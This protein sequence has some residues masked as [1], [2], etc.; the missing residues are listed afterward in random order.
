MLRLFPSMA[1]VRLEHTWS[2]VLGV[3][4]DWSASVNYNRATGLVTAGGYV[5]HGVA[6]TN[7]AAR[8]VRDLILGADTEI[9]ALP[10]VG[11]RSRSWEPEPTRWIGATSLYAVYGMADRLERRGTKPSKI[12]KLADYVSGRH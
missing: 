7:L 6:G 1:G 2:G 9:T 3:P 11:Y 4:R 12:G 10:W 5:G 8:T